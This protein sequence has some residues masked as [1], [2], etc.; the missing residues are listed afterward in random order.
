MTFERS[1]D[2]ELIRKIVTHPKLYPHV[3]DDFS[4]DACDYVPPGAGPYLIYLLA[5]DGDELLGMFLFV[6]HTG[7]CWE[8]HTCLLPNAWGSRARLAAIGAAEWMFEH[9]PCRRIITNVPSYNRLALRFARSA[10]MKEFGIN[11]RSYQKNGT[12]HDQVVLGLSPQE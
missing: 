7:I 3:S 4:P 9:T 2:Y 8:V 10:G 5:K 1:D 6:A 12:L 11:E